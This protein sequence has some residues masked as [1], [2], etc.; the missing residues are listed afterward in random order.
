MLDT[1][2]IAG[3]LF[4]RIKK[5]LPDIMEHDKPIS[6]LNER[7]RFLRYKGGGILLPHIMMVNLLDLIIQKLVI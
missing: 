3:C 4:E 7:L 6:C 5:Y 1:T 2:E